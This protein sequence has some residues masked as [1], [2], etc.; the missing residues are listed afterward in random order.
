MSQFLTLA[1]AISQ[2][3]AFN[4]TLGYYTLA[5]TVLDCLHRLR[6]TVNLNSTCIRG[7]ISASLELVY[8]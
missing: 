7:E 6:Y 2:S 5:G 1:T 4:S 8:N 3:P